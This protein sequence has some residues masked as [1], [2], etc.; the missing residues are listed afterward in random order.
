MG[1]INNHFVV[2]QRVNVLILREESPKGEC[3]SN[4]RMAPPKQEDG[5]AIVSRRRGGGREEERLR[6][7][8]PVRIIKYE[9]VILS[10]L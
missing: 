6:W 3:V 5:G 7:I 2:L 8:K 4:V 10:L 1:N 9:L